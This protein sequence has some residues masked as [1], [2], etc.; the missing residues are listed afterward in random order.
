MEEKVT[1][2]SP[3][4]DFLSFASQ[5][6]ADQRNALMVFYDYVAEYQVIPYKIKNKNFSI[7]VSDSQSMTLE[8]VFENVI[9]QDGRHPMEILMTKVKGETLQ[10]EDGTGAY[11]ISFINGQITDGTQKE[12]AFTFDG[13]HTVLKLWNYDFNTYPFSAE[14]DKIPWRLIYEPISSFIYKWDRLGEEGMNSEEVACATIFQ[15]IYHYVGLYLDHE[16]FVGYGKTA[17]GYDKDLILG[18]P[19]NGRMRLAAKKV[20]E[21][22]GWQDML[23]LLEHYEQDPEALFKA[24]IIKLAGESGQALY[25]YVRDLLMRCTAQYPKHRDLLPIYAGRRSF[26]KSVMDDILTA[27]GYTGTYPKY[28]KELKP[29]FIETSFVYERKYTYMNEK[30]KFHLI[31]IIESV[32][33]GGLHLSALSGQ[34]LVKDEEEETY[35][36]DALNCCF[37]N[38]GRKSVIMSDGLY[39][40]PDVEEEELQAD[41]YTYIKTIE[42]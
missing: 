29:K 23:S 24:W 28:K 40:M 32:V 27:H 4:A 39:I 6:S 13:I 38:A 15:F 7:A 5:F 26:A 36:K 17:V 34:M 30:K 10:S 8:L 21:Q 14:S 42:Q 16:T 37:A 41:I 35:V 9:I 1:E 3:R 31:D 20:F 12:S 33:D 19:L 2:Q 11:K 18:N 25:D 22:L